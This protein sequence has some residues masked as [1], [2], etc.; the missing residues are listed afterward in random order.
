MYNYTW[1]PVLVHRVINGVLMVGELSDIRIKKL[2]NKVV[3]SSDPPSPLYHFALA[4]LLSDN[5]VKEFLKPSAIK[6]LIYYNMV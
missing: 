3:A 2:F 5:R 1:S 6:M 4:Y